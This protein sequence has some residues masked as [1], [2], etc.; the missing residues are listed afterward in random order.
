MGVDA[1]AVV[2]AD[3]AFSL[4]YT[5]TGKAEEFNPPQ[6]SDFQVLAGPTSSTMSSTSI[7]NGKRTHT[8]EI[9]YTY[10]LQPTKEGKFTIPSAS[11]K[12]DGKLYSS[13]SVSI[14]VGAVICCCIVCRFSVLGQAVQAGDRCR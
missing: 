6:I 4:V 3:E 12:I 13:T 5:A 11:V 8:Y 1:P 2:T 9:S 14:E 10:I 7:I